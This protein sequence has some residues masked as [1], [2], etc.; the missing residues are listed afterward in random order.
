MQ[1]IYA[2]T[3][4]KVKIAKNLSFDFKVKKGLD[5]KKLLLFCCL[6]FYQKSQLEEPKQKQMEIYSINAI[7]L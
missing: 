2:S 4:A 3:N 5:K 6:M 7:E 1:L